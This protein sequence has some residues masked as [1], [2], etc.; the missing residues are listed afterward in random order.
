M[1][2]SKQ[3]GEPMPQPIVFY[4]EFN[5]PYAY[6]GAHLIDEAAAR[7][8]REVDW[9]C[10]SLGHL[11]K[12]IGYNP[13]AML[14]RKM[15]YMRRDWERAAALE[16]LPIAQPKPFPADSKLARLA[17]WRLKARD[18]GLARR[19]ALAVY[20]RYWGLGQ[21]ITGLEHL[22]GLAEGLRIARG[23]LA[24]ALADEAAKKAVMD[25]T[26]EAAERGAFGTPSFLVDGEL[27]WGHDRIPHIERWL[28]AKAEAA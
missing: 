18:A 11:W 2:E 15:T 25:A 1:T 5:S 4:F 6:I 19:F 14:D 22:A 21:D 20:D 24:A 23:E 12:A 17:F 27:F 3:T 26:A 9:K 28:V 8:G 7:H 13:A 16:G 10:I